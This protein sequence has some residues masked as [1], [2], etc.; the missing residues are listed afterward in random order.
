MI[1]KA[2][3]AILVLSPFS[4]ASAN[5]IDFKISS[6]TA[7]FTFLTE[8]STFGY[9]GADVGYGVFIDEDDDVLASG[10]I[11][12]SGSSSGDLKAL[13]FGVGVKAYA[14]K[15]NNPLSAQDDKGAAFALGAKVRYVFP[16]PSPMAAVLEG[17]VA[18]TVT[19]LGD[20]EGVSE[21]RAG[22]EFEV[23]PSARAY[24][25]YMNVEVDTSATTSV[26]L[27]DSVHIGV[28]FSY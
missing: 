19:S 28:R 4:N 2:L 10:S 27:D 26:E 8:A 12:V 7:E 22:I 25:G 23:T 24:L 16:G 1:K 14:G 11:L 9:G 18:P 13:Q 5:A 6:E 15:I 17:Y 3:L 21:V 20:F